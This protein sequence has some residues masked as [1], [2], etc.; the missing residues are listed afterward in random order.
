MADEFMRA[1]IDEA[2]HGLREA[3][4]RTNA[5]TFVSNG[6][7]GFPTTKTVRRRTR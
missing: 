7:H 3:P 2:G 4:F 6:M 1:A 5:Y